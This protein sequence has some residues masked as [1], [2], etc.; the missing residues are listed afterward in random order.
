MPVNKAKHSLCINDLSNMH[1][2]LE[3]NAIYYILNMNIFI[4]E[5]TL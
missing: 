5:A 2:I 4:N 3:A 1:Y